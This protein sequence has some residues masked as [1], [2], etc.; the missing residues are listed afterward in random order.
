M[1]G[2]KVNLAIQLKVSLEDID[3]P[4]WRRL[5]M[6]G[7]ASL[8]DLHWTIQQVM[9]WLNYHLHEFQVGERRV[10]RPDY[11]DDDFWLDD[12]RSP[13]EDARAITLLS[14]L[15]E[16]VTEFHYTYDFGDDWHLSIRLERAIDVDEPLAA[17]ECLEG[18]RAGPPE[19]CGG[20]WGFMEMLESIRNPSD[21][22][23]D[24][25]MNW[26]PGVYDPEAFNVA[27]ANW[28]LGQRMPAE[29]DIHDM[30]GWMG[31]VPGRLSMAAPYYMRLWWALMTRECSSPD[32]AAAVAG[33]VID[34][35]GNHRDVKMAR[36]TPYQLTAL[37]NGEW[38]EE[39]TGICLHEDLEVEKL[40]DSRMLMNARELLLLLQER[41]SVRTTA[42]GNLPRDFVQELAGRMV[43]P[44]AKGELM[45]KHTRVWNEESIWGIYELRELLR[46]TGLL[47]RYKGTF[48]ITR[49]GET[50]LRPEHS[51]RLLGHL[52]RR[53]F[54]DSRSSV[55]EELSPR[56]AFELGIPYMIY[57][58]AQFGRSWQKPADIAD[59]LVLGYVRDSFHMQIRPEESAD[60]VESRFLRP[61]EELGLAERRREAGLE[62]GPLTT[63][64]RSTPLFD[65]FVSFVF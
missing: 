10:G 14:L 46:L 26:L 41:G 32:E 9:G 63:V 57:R 8:E 31:A 48:R 11:M 30:L 43:W 47:R 7:E 22:E 5:L 45:F 25:W 36:L 44:P 17:P 42:R 62:D 33:E 34:H 37:I 61:L 24:E 1:N 40:A 2:D 39:G 60:L 18:E 21:P 38:T 51:S 19:D 20:P 3:P 54:R 49:R 58:W 50:L 53:L 28:I 16:G 65:R 55:L 35:F 52:F 13:L 6:P 59:E 56:T 23:H 4:I 12:P 27:G 29:P 64:Y 15:N